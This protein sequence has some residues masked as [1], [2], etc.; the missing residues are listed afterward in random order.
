MPKKTTE[1]SETPYIKGPKAQ[2]PQAH[3]ADVRD[4][5]LQETVTA[6]K[7]SQQTNNIMYIALLAVVAFAFYL[8]GKDQ[9]GA[10]AGGTGTGG[11]GTQAQ[12]AA[13]QPEAAPKVELKDIKALFSKDNM[14]FGNP[15][16][17]LL[18]V[19]VSDPS[20]P[21]CHIAAGKNAELA[22]Q[23]GSRFQ[24]VSDGGSYVPPVP[25]M[26]KLV[27]Q[28]KAALVTIYSNGHGNGE[29]AFQAL[30]CAHEKG[31]FWPVHDL[32]YTNA[33]YELINNTVKN[34]PAK[35]PELAKF[36]GS[37]V[38]SRFMEDC[39]KSGKYKGEI[40]KDQ[41]LAAKIGVRG[42]PGFYV[43]TTNFAGAYSYADMESVVQEALK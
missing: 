1:L 25:E 24:Y 42:T 20:C 4:N 2:E 31:Q 15:N 3:T 41:S 37:A 12:A 7:K 26:K 39:L 8:L 19:D 34:D 21:F 11:T 32:L 14:Y 23:V 18:F 40:A 13:Q 16:A 28:G 36:L 22:K 5:L 17:K 27:D 30:H 29:L 43:N 38:D 35:A 9:A 6:L 33:G 10:V